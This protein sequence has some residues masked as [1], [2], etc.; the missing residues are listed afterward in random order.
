MAYPLVEKTRE[1]SETGRHL[2]T[3]DYPKTPS[4]CRHGVGVGRQM[5]SPKP[6]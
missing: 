1:R 4:L 2:V 5:T 6:C 3:E